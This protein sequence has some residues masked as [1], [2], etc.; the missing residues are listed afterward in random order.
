[1]LPGEKVLVESVATPLAFKAISPRL[2]LPSKK[3]MLP[4]GVLAVDV[5]VAVSVTVAAAAAG[6]GV[7]VNARLVVAGGTALTTRATAVEV[8][9]AKAVVAA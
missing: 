9:A 3:A 6:F 4:V 5:M 7:A 2:V 8:L 1:V